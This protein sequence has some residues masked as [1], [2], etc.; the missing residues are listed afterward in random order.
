M[1]IKTILVDHAIGSIEDWIFRGRIRSSRRNLFSCLLCVCSLLTVV[2][3][4]QR[5]T[6]PADIK[7]D[8]YAEKDGI[9]SIE[10]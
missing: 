1:H 2:N 3:C 8:S 7:G 9:G 4:G 5:K 6:L 10:D